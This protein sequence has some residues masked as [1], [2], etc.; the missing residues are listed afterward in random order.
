MKKFFAVLLTAVMLLDAMSAA[1]EEQSVTVAVTTPMTG[2]FFTSMWGNNTSDADVRA[3]IHGCELVVWDANSGA[4]VPNGTVIEK[5]VA[6]EEF[7]GD[8]VYSIVLNKN[9]AYCD[10]TPITAWDYAFSL[11]LMISPEIAEIGANAYKPAWISGYDAYIGGKSETLTGVRVVSDDQLTITISGKYLPFFYELALLALTPYPA[12]EIAPGVSIAD[13]GEGIYIVDEDGAFSAELLSRTILDENTGYRSHPA[14]TS[15]PYK[16]VSYAN[17]EAVFELN[18]YYPGDYRGTKPTIERVTFKCMPADEMIAAIESGEVTVINKATG[19]EL[20]DE[21]I[22][23]CDSGAGVNFTSY[24]RTGVGLISLN[25]DSGLLTDVNVRRAL[26]YGIDKDELTS[27]TVGDYGAATNGW[28]GLGQW[29]PSVLNGTIPYP[30]TKPDESD[31]AAT[32][33]YE[34]SLAK[35][36]SLSLNSLDIYGRDVD[37][38]GELLAEAG[39]SLNEQG[40]DYDQERDSLRFR[41]G[42]DGLEPLSLK[43]AYPE[44]SAVGKALEQ[45]LPAQLAELGATVSVESVPLAELLPQY[46]HT[47]ECKYDMIF[48][49]TNFDLLYDPSQ[50]FSLNEDGEHVWTYTGLADE[51]L[52]RLAVRLRQ[53]KPGDLFDYCEKWLEY[54]MRFMEILPAIPIYSNYY[55]DF[56]SEDLSNYAINANTSWPQAL[57]AASIAE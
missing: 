38:A 26:A 16:L 28:Y 6:S 1:A 40:G 37:V 43:L 4:F 55:F 42:E 7:D 52:Y 3:L 14:L 10:G 17:G 21:G 41:E 46:Y 27:E 54:E 51:E 56:Y 29:M 20:I 39:W 32:A 47:A 23:L 45:M 35:W 19:R 9:L 34:K 30:V 22:A 13:D 44:G 53:I 24:A 15:G 8:H 25:L 36:Q 57:N 18:P 50:Q 31:A 2:N 11:L 48:M 12:S 5:L 33:A 49:A